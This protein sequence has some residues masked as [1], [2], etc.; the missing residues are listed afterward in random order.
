MNSVEQFLRNDIIEY[1]GLYKKKLS[2]TE[3]EI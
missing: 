3:Y 2:T 1:E